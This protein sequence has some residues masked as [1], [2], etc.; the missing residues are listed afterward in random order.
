MMNRK[1]TTATI[2]DNVYN[3]LFHSILNLTLA[4]GSMVSEKDIAEKLSVSRTPVR[5]AF[6]KLAKEGL[7]F[8]YPQRGT[9]I[10]KINFSRAREEKFIR[11]SLEKECFRL[12]IAIADE[13]THERF[14]RNIEKQEKAILAGDHIKF[15]EYDDLFHRIAFEE[16]K[17]LLCHDVIQKM[18]GNYRR[19]RILTNKELPAMEHNLQEH[20]D[21]VDALIERDIEK[22][23]HILNVHLNK[24]SI[25]SDELYEK[26]PTYFDR[27]ELPYNET[28]V[29]IERD[30]LFNIL[31]TN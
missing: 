2:G 7:V 8:I 17:R 12:F 15:L 1:I 25:E 20:V 28:V 3:L 13:Q 18:C 21:L 16:T 30:E 10:S 9:F 29:E 31:K 24:I 4:P 22:T 14:R 23:L 11:E 6:I 19:I 27:G 26:F 5:E